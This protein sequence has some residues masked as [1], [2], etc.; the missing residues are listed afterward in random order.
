M[1]L[2]IALYRRGVTML[3]KRGFKIA[4][5][6]RTGGEGRRILVFVKENAGRAT[7]PAIRERQS[8]NL[9]QLIIHRMT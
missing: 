4:T 3:L 8:D 6:R 9:Q 2:A 1:S 7:T 5:A